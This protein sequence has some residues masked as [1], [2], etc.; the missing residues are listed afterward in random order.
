MST[1]RVSISI[2]DAHLDQI[3]EITKSLQSAGMEVEQT[4]STVG[5]IN[6]SVDSEQVNRLYQ[7]EGVQH[8]EPQ[9]S[10]HLAPPDSDIQ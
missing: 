1:V 3:A 4:L 6:G 7:I 5:V 9:Q 2:D 8:I 10:Y